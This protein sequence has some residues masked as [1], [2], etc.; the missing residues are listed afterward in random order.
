LELCFEKGGMI[1]NELT[2]ETERHQYT[3]AYISL[4]KSFYL[5]M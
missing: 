4:V 5:K 3:E 1:T 2:I